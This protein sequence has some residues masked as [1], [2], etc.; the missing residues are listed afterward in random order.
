[1][2]RASGY[3][4][5]PIAAVKCEERPE[6]IGEATL[7]QRGSIRRR[8][9]RELIV[10]VSNV[11]RLKAN[12][13]PLLADNTGMYVAVLSDLEKRTL[14][15]CH[16]SESDRIALSRLFFTYSQLGD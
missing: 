6:S 1:M 14:Q 8:S 10:Q 15:M 13:D 5:E 7:L 9:K 16:V 12:S 4:L 11:S 3:Q 2:E